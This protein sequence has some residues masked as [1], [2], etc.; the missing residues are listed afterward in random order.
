M[1]FFG[2]ALPDAAV[3][4]GAGTSVFLA[5]DLPRQAR[6]RTPRASI[7]RV[8][9]RASAT[10]TVGPDDEVIA[11]G[12]AARAPELARRVPEL[13]DGSR[14]Y[15]AEDAEGALRAVSVDRGRARPRGRFRDENLLQS[16]WVVRATRVSER[17]TSE[18]ASVVDLLEYLRR[19]MLCA[20][21][22]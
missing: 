5:A 15:V 16:R 1:R 20:T 9:A 22:R 18:R 13:R 21:R 8:D 19:T 10:S 7:A 11:G 14:G 3:T 17:A 4:A 12:A 6:A 2:E